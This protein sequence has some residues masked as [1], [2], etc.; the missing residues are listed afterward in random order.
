M[1]P[2]LERREPS[3]GAA[4]LRDADVVFRVQAKLR[5]SQFD[6]EVVGAAETADADSFAFEL[7]RRL[8]IGQRD[9]AVGQ[10]I[11]DSAD[12]F[13]LGAFQISVDERSPARAHEIQDC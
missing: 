5:Q 9:E 6:R 3:R 7:R 13:P 2:R 8:D 12:D 11:I 10:A 1:L 4:D